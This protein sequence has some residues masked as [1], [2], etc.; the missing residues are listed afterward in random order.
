MKRHFVKTKGTADPTQV[1]GPEKI[2]RTTLRTWSGWGRIQ[3]NE[4]SENVL[5]FGFL[6]V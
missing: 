2:F 1:N 4:L 6:S 3:V 5:C